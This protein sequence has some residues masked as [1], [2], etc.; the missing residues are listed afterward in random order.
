MVLYSPRTHD[1]KGKSELVKP[2]SQF[3]VKGLAFSGSGLFM[4]G[5]EL[6]N[7]QKDV[8]IESFLRMRQM[9]PIVATSLAASTHKDRKSSETSAS[10]VAEGA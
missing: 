5:G 10:S 8:R 3:S 7:I 6:S 9:D 4:I 2:R 1:S